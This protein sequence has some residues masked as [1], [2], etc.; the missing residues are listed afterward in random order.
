MAAVAAEADGELLF[1]QVVGVQPGLT[2]TA[3]EVVQGVITEQPGA[4][5]GTRGSIE[6]LGRWNEKHD[7]PAMPHKRVGGDVRLAFSKLV[8]ELVQNGASS[9]IF[10]IWGQSIWGQG[11][12]SWSASPDDKSYQRHGAPD[13]AARL[14]AE[15]KKKGKEPLKIRF[16]DFEGAVDVGNQNPMA[17]DFGALSQMAVYRVTLPSGGLDPDKW[18]GRP[19]PPAPEDLCTGPRRDGLLSTEEISGDY[20]AP[21]CVEGKI[22][23]LICRSMTVVPHGPDMIETWSTCCLFFPP[24]IIWPMAGGEVR[25]RDPGTNAFDGMTFSADGTAKQTCGSYKK[26]P[27]S[28]K[29][30]FQKVET[31]DLAGRWRGCGCLPLLHVFCTTKKALNE[32]QYAESGLCCLCPVCDTFTRRYVNG[33]A[34]NGFAKDNNP[35]DVHWH[36]DPGCAAMCPFIFAKKVG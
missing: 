20:S 14:R 23:H 28:Q 9:G 35:G 26:R 31:R 12:F 19:P 15:A 36:R 13:E 3:P 33:H 29:R 8:D 18:S 27:T 4:N 21:G 16:A 34:T 6:S 24:F 1:G 5:A 7:D 30:A 10:S 22:W 11:Q 17:D 2:T 32:D 25:T